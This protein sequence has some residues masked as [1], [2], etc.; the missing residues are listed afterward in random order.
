MSRERLLPHQC[1]QGGFC[2]LGA[3]PVLPWLLGVRNCSW[4]EAGLASEDF[5]T[6]C[7]FIQLCSGDNGVSLRDAARPACFIYPGATQAGILLEQRHSLAGA[8]SWE[9]CSSLPS[10]LEIN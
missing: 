10:P 5:P 4:G 8:V 1:P 9:R 6:F 7:V 3:L 2:S